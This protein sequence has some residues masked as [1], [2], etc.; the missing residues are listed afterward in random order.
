MRMLPPALPLS[1]TRPCAPAHEEPPCRTRQAVGPRR[2]GCPTRTR[3]SRRA[4]LAVLLA[5][6]T[7]TR[8]RTRRS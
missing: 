7:R 2:A 1:E 5:P 3:R 6:R 8:T 4:W